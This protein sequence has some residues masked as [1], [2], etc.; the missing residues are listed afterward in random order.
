PSRSGDHAEVDDA[1]QGRAQ[2]SGCAATDHRLASPPLYWAVEGGRCL[3][4]MEDSLGIR[5]AS[6]KRSRT[7]RRIAGTICGIASLLIIAGAQAQDRGDANCDG[8]VDD[9]DL[10]ALISRIFAPQE[11]G[12]ADPNLDG[13][14]SAPDLMGEIDLLMITPTPSETIPPTATET[15]TPALGPVITYLGL[16]GSGGKLAP[17]SDVTEDGIPII[18][19][20]A[21]VGFKI[22]VEAAPGIT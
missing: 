7:A 9:A 18:N 13:V 12:Q 17:V 15:P 8:T 5:F 19:R 20:A 22:V 14:T 16:A 4:R 21:A 2:L 6:R 1:S 3:R 11:C 10:T